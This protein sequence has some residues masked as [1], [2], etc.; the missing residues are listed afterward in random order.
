M[1]WAS[2]GE[3]KEDQVNI[4]H[5]NGAVHK[6]LFSII[7]TTTQAIQPATNEGQQT[8]QKVGG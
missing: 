6:K 2:N 3:E 5:S 7:E 4:F 8:Q 1:R